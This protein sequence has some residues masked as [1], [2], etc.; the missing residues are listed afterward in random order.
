MH[1]NARGYV[2]DSFQSLQEAKHC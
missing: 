1:Q 2:Q